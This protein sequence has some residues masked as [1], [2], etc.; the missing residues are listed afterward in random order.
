MMRPENFLTKC[1]D[2]DNPPRLDRSK[3]AGTLSLKEIRGL[4]DGNPHDFEGTR[5]EAAR[6]LLLLWHDHWE[7]AHAIAQSDEGEPHHDLMHAI[8]H[9]REE[10]FAN[11]GYWFR[12]AGEHEAFKTLAGRARGLLESPDDKFVSSLRARVLPAGAWSAKGFLEAVKAAKTTKSPARD[13]EEK[14]LR[15]LQAEE[16]ITAFESWTNLR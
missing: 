6:G 2:R 14:V 15:A 16:I 12:E 8:A 7:D 4:I 1:F 11:A 5:G 10:D 3:R 13:A 9:R